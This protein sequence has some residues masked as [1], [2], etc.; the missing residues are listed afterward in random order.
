MSIY[1]SSCPSKRACFLAFGVFDAFGSGWNWSFNISSDRLCLGEVA[2]GAL[3]LTLSINPPWFLGVM[4]VST[5]LFSAAAFFVFNW[6][7]R[8]S[9]D[10]VIVLSKLPS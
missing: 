1:S 9:S 4:S 5:I 8:P 2:T 7:A 10:L 3:V 6:L